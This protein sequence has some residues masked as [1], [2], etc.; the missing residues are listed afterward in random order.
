MLLRNWR[1][2][3]AIAVL[4]LA[5]VL[6]GCGRS[7]RKPGGKMLVAASIAPLANWSKEVG[8][9][10]VEVQLLVPPGSNPHVYQPEPAQMSFL[11]DASVLVLNGL[12]L[13]FWADKAVAAVGNPKMIV[14]RTAN[15]LKTLDAASDPDSPGGN[16]HVWVDPINAIHQV[17][18][19]RDAF[20]KADPRHKAQYAANADRYVA[21]L[22][23]LDRDIR[24]EVKTFT[25]KQFIAFHPSWVYFAHEYGLVQ[26]T[27][28][29]KAPGR[30]LSAAE[31]QA[32]V[33][34]AKRIHAK[35]V[36]AEAQTSPKATEVVAREVGAKVLILDPLGKPP[37]Y[38]YIETMRY[39]LGQMAKALK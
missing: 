5:V 6:A 14:V 25:N 38:D 20:I 16:P 36:F 11:S 33:D 21:K 12:N 17:N 15:G 39:D 32:I 3:A 22:R 13:E 26:A 19:I 24:A 7:V 8:G 4:I 37:D 29:E 35:A 2:A 10:L 9:D 23:Q 27:T 34:T 31:M 18:A 30:E 1:Y 28:I